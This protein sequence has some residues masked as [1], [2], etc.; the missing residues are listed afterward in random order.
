MDDLQS[1]IDFKDIDTHENIVKLGA[2]QEIDEE[3][4]INVNDEVGN[5]TSTK[6]TNTCGISNR[7]RNSFV[8]KLIENIMLGGILKKAKCKYSQVELTSVG[9]RGT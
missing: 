1:Q 5:H 2:N 4:S 3:R 7:K 8:W 9:N 6:S